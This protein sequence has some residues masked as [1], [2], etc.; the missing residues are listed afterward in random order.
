M[1]PALSAWIE[2]PEPGISTSTTESA[3]SITSTSAWPTPTVSRKT[4]SLPAASISSAACSAA[5]ASPPSAPRRRHRADEDAGVEEVLGQPD[6][7]AEQRAAAERRRRVD[8]EHGDLAVGGAAELDQRAD[9]RRLA[10]AGRPGE[11]DD[12]RVAGLRVDLADER[13]ALG[14]VV[15]DQRDAARQRALVAG[16]QALGEGGL[17]VGHRA[18]KNTISPDGHPARTGSATP[19]SAALRRRCTAVRSRSL[20][21]MRAQRDARPAATARLIVALGVAEAALARAAA[22]RR[23]VLRRPRRDVRDRQGRARAARPLVLDR[24][25]LEDPRPRGRGRDRREDR[26]RPGVHDLRLPAR[27]RS[28]ANASSPT[29]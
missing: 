11:A 15:L 27:R 29:A 18:A 4:S 9:Q 26:A 5:S 23:A 25:R 12:R 14:V 7:V 6:A 16:E 21:F 17:L 20:R 2:S 8:R 24:P 3:W 19:R 28:G 10:G 13:P 22:D 1:T